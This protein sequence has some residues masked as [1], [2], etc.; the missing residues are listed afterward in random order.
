MRSPTEVVDRGDVREE[1]EPFRVT[2]ML[3]GREQAGRVD[4]D[5]R[6]VV[7]AANLD[8]AGDVGKRL[9]AQEATLRSSYAGGTPAR[10]ASCRRTMPSIN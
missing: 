5:G 2:E 6:L 9:R 1:V 4:D 10:T 8:D 3:R 7:C